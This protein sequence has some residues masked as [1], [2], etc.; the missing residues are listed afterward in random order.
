MKIKIS[1]QF[2]LMGVFLLTAMALLTTLAVPALAASPTVNPAS[3]SS[4]PPV[5]NAAV[6]PGVLTISGN[7]LTITPE[8]TPLAA[9]TVS[10]NQTATVIYDKTSGVVQTITLNKLGP[11][12]AAPKLANKQWAAVRG[13]LAVTGNITT[14][15]PGGAVSATLVAPPND[16][17]AI[18][19]NKITGAI[20]GFTLNYAVLKV[21]P[22]NVTVAS[23]IISIAPTSV[24]SV[25]LTVTANQTATITYNK[26]T[27]I[28]Q[29]ITLLKPGANLPQTSNKTWGVVR[30]VVTAANNIITITPVKAPSVALKAAAGQKANLSYNSKTGIVSVIMLAKPVPAP[31]TPKNQTLPN[32]KK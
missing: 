15:T 21:V 19:Y 12:A 28:I 17:V 7:I 31:S 6:L 18:R 29:A 23:N 13:A 3:N 22:A 8:K 2:I 11:A 16:G 25:A 32:G 26:K 30:G 27:G 10:A 24:P 5:T 20:L 1:R 14:I 9:L 4:V